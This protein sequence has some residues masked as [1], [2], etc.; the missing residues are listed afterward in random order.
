MTEKKQ[1]S[2]NDSMTMNSVSKWA[3]PQRWIVNN[4]SCVFRLSSS[5]SSDVS[6]NAST[7]HAES[8]FLRREN[9]LSARKKAEEETANNDYKKAGDAVCMLMNGVCCFG[10]HVTKELNVITWQLT[11]SLRRLYCFQ[12]MI[13]STGASSWCV[14]E[15]TK[16]HPL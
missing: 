6:N 3:Q 5:G 14:A 12:A 11:N 8:Y 9:R 4:L 1:E 10:A 7:N 2:I 13:F 15:G 16:G